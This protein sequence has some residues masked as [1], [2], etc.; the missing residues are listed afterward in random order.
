MDRCKPVSKLLFV[1][2][3]NDRDL[4]ATQQMEVYIFTKTPPK[5]YLPWFGLNE[6][7]GELSCC[8]YR[9]Y[10]LKYGTMTATCKMAHNLE[11][12]LLPVIFI[13]SLHDYCYV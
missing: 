3:Y 8:F 1:V 5:V 13:S 11:Y 12:W 9:H 10:L 4:C 7:E 6:Q 2:I